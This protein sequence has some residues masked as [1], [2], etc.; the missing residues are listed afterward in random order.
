MESTHRAFADVVVLAPLGRLD[1]K[2]AG[3]FERALLPLLDPA[4]GSRAGVVLDLT[5]VDYISSVS[6]R[7]LMIATKAIRGRGARIAVAG[8]QRT[9]EEIF[10]ISRF[11]N[12]V[13]IFATVDAALAA[14]SPAA[15]AA[16]ASDG[17]AR[18]P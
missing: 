14:L 15:A 9:V 7:V 13:E 12:V 6:L 11:N 10:A 3:E 2:A 17:K 18:A 1:Y 16:S 4:A 8:L 5:N